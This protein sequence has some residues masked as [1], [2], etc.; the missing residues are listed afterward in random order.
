MLNIDNFSHGRGVGWLFNVNVDF[1]FYPGGG[2]FVE[3][4]DDIQEIFCVVIKQKFN[5]KFK[6]NGDVYICTIVHWIIQNR[7]LKIFVFK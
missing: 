1:K 6:R 5:W 3:Y 4:E 7:N 2:Q